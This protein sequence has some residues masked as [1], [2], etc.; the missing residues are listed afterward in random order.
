MRLFAYGVWWE[1][2]HRHPPRGHPEDPSSF[3]SRFVVHFDW[4][5][6]QPGANPIVQTPPGGIEGFNNPLDPGSLTTPLDS[7]GPGPGQWPG[8]P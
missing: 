6:T 7:G 5:Q 8:L 4:F 3:V 1:V 2:C